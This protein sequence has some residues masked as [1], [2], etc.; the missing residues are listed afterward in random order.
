M[1]YGMVIFPLMFKF[2]SYTIENFTYL[3]N[4]IESYPSVFNSNLMA[5]QQILTPSGEIVNSEPQTSSAT[6]GDIDI[7]YGLLL[8]DRLWGK[9]DTIDYKSEALKR[10]QALMNSCVDKNDYILNLGDWVKG[11]PNSTFKGVTRS[12]DFMIY[13]LR[14]FVEVDVKNSGSWNA[15]INKISDIINEQLDRE[16]KNNGLM[17]DFFIKDNNIF[18]APKKKILETLHDGDYYYNSC[19]IPWRYSMDIL[20]NKKTITKQLYTLNKWIIKET[21]SNPK[22]IVSGYYVTNDV[23]GN[24][25]GSSNNLSFVSP[26][27]VLSLLQKENKDWTI[28]LWK[29]II[30]TPIENS[31]FYG[32]TLKLIAMIVA[33]E[34]WINIS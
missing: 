34:N 14:K 9:K 32:N 20:L 31:N 22:N 10:I 19:R 16:S 33:T 30:E 13:I 2:D 5:W 23:P 6:D 8:A 15:V 12:S 26:F 21:N 4:Y 7:S 29:H 25:F 1:G 28:A 24:P 27:L 17:P 3:Y 18:I 11:I